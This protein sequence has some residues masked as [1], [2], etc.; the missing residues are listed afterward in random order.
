MSLTAPTFDDCLPLMRLYAR[1]DAIAEGLAPGDSSAVH[2]AVLNR[3][4]ANQRVAESV[5]WTACALERHG[6]T[7]RLLL[8][9]VRP[10][11][12]GRE[13]VPDWIPRLPSDVEPAS[14]PSAE[15]PPNGSPSRERY[16]QIKA[17]IHAQLLAAS[18]PLPTGGFER[19][20]S[21]L[22]AATAY[23]HAAAPPES[24]PTPGERPRSQARAR[25]EAGLEARWLDDGGA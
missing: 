8:L 11:G 12:L 14:M 22:A 13:V 4:A 21:R 25:E 7:G 17:V 15:R 18:P 1:F 10:A 3:L 19:L 20:A 9:G 24:E 5:G 2:R 6:G 16:R 23:R